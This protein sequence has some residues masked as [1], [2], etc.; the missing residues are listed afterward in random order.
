M[1]PKATGPMTLSRIGSNSENERLNRSLPGEGQDTAVA[2]AFTVGLWNVPS[3][4]CINSAASVFGMKGSP[5]S[6]RRFFPSAVLSSAGTAYNNSEVIL[7]ETLRVSHCYLTSTE[8][9]VLLCSTCG[10]AA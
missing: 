2:L 4:G 5:K 9:I 1:Q 6:T 7:L 3:P 8:C 10:V